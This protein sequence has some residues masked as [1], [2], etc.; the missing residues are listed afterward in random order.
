MY[1]TGLLVTGVRLG[2]CCAG[3]AVGGRRCC[4]RSRPWS[5]QE[6]RP[7][8]RQQLPDRGGVQ[9]G[10][11]RG[12]AHR[13]L[14]PAPT[15]ATPGT[16]ASP[17]SGRSAGC[18]TSSA[19]PSRRSTPTAA[20]PASATWRSTIAISSSVTARR[21]S[22]WRPGCRLAP[23]D[24]QRG[25]RSRHR[26]RRAPGQPAGQLRAWARDRD[27][28]ERRASPWTANRGPTWT[29]TRGERRLA[30]AP[31]V[32]LLLEAVWDT[33][34]RTTRC[35][36][37]PGVRWAHDFAGGLQIVPGS[38]TPS[39]SAPTPATTPLPL[40]Q[41]RAPF[42]PP[43]CAPRSNRIRL[44]I[45]LSLLRLRSVSSDLR[46]VLASALILLLCA[47]PWP[48]PPAAANDPRSPSSAPWPSSWA[49][50]SA[51][52]SGWAPRPTRSTA[53]RWSRR[54]TSPGPIRRRSPAR[55][56]V[57]GCTCPIWPRCSA[58][59]TGWTGSA[60]GSAPA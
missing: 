9:P 56:S 54:S 5:A 18:A 25:E 2:A 35:F 58:P 36:L 24:R 4:W 59:P 21:P 11:R 34:A 47:A 32:N 52:R 23:A 45:L 33:S 37:N 6:P 8:R 22:T 10:S 31:V 57:S 55:R 17:R 42:R 28:L 1:V 29:S 50:R 30:G 60:W 16:S 19:T 15:A 12:A 20:A 49:S 38:P 44:M 39:A 41:L 7:H 26:L 13:H 53:S 46:G 40:S 3:A 48:E 27:P 51:T 43:E 14:R